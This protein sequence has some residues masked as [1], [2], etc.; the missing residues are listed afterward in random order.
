MIPALLLLGAASVAAAFVKAWRAVD[1][2]L[3]LRR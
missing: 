1:R 3:D 2:M